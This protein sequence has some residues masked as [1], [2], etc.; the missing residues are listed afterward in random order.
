M[1]LL[2]TQL[3]LPHTLREQSFEA[4]GL[5]DRLCVDI[6]EPSPTT[7]SRKKVHNDRC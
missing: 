3:I 6:C 5:G 1:A 7:R 2:V 4:N